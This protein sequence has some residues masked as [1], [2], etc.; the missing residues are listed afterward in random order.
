MSGIFRDSPGVQSR[1]HDQTVPPVACD[2]F[3]ELVA[4]H[5][6]LTREERLQVDLAWRADPQGAARSWLLMAD[7]IRDAQA[8]RSRPGP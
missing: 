4:Q 7:E 8:A 2:G 1:G 6:G 5:F 3:F